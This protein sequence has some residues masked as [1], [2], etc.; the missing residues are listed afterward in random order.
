MRKLIVLNGIPRSGKDTVAQNIENWLSTQTVKQYRVLYKR[1]S[2]ID[3]YKEFAIRF[4]GWDGKK[5]ESGRRLLS[6]L[7]EASIRYNDGPF[8]LIQKEFSDVENSFFQQREFFSDKRP[9]YICLITFCREPEEIKK[10]KDCYNESCITICV[11]RDINFE[12]S[13]YADVKEY[14]EK[15]DYDYYI[16]NNSDLAALEKR[17]FELCKKIF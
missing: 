2:T 7:K 16:D 9:S 13:C 1:F 5:D 12:V 8:K 15:Y 6:D 4:F 14:I 3:Y 10:L 11:K 17:T